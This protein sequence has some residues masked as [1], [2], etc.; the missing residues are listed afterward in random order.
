MRK[1]SIFKIP[2]PLSFTILNRAGTLKFKVKVELLN[3]VEEVVIVD[4]DCVQEV[5][6]LVEYQSC[7]VELLVVPYLAC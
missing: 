7:Q 1:L 2:V 6:L 4:P 3:D 5:P